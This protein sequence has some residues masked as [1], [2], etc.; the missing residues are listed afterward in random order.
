MSE[1][2]GAFL[3]AERLQE[4]SYSFPCCFD[5][6][7]VRLSDERLEL[8]E[9]HLDGIEVWTVWRQEKEMCADIPDR[10][11]GRLSFVAPEIVEDD[12]IASLQ[13]WDQALP[14]P[15][16]KGDAV[17]GAI[18]DEGGQR[19]CRGAGRPETSASSNDHEG[20]LR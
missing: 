15:C 2:V 7:L 19:C 12:D 3:R 1:V 16:G 17:D 14:D 4:F 20:L 11:S 13:S 5:G 8:G 9:H 10:V 18:E 6:S